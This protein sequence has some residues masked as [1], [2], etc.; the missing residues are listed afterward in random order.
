MLLPATS[1]KSS[2]ARATKRAMQPQRNSGGRLVLGFIT[3]AICVQVVAAVLPHLLVSLVV[4]AVI[5]IAL[6]LV[7]FHTRRW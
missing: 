5:V 4:L 6:R 3:C 2:S 1:P 7:F